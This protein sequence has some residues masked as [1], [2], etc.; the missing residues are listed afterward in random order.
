LVNTFI[1]EDIWDPTDDPGVEKFGVSALK[2]DYFGWHKNG[3]NAQGDTLGVY[4]PV[5]CE[6]TPRQIAAWRAQDPVKRAYYG[7]VP[8]LF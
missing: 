1:K 8:R 6:S 4:Y 2:G 7:T 5:Y 3:N